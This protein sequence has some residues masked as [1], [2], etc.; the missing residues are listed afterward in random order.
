MGTALNLQ[1]AFGKM[2]IFTLLILQI[3]V[4]ER[5]FNVLIFHN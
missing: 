5:S 1:I 2:V 3:H 4:H